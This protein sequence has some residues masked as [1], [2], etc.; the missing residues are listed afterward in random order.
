MI[1]SSLTTGAPAAVTNL[2]A[3]I[4]GILGV[5]GFAI[6]A[7]GGKQDSDGQGTNSSPYLNKSSAQPAKVN[8]EMEES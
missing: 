3:P 1:F 5:A 2:S 4:F 7:I 8:T 6:F